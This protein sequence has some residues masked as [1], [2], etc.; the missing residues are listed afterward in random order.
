VAEAGIDASTVPVPE[1]MFSQKGAYHAA[2][3]L[4][5]GANPPDAI[6]AASDAMAFGVMQAARRLDLRVPEELG[7][8][9]FDGIEP[10]RVWQW[11]LS[12]VRQPVRELGTV[13]MS[14]LHDL[15]NNRRKGPEQVWLETELVLR[16]SCGCRSPAD[17]EAEPRSG[18]E[19]A[20]AR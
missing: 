13:A 5:G 9:G 18:K 15:V 4:L 16:H 14:R 10:D 6:F 1:V 20:F 8:M 17:I 2:L 7:L 3:R 19:G 12:T 11:D